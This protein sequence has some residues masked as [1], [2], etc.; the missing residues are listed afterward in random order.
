MAFVQT[1]KEAVKNLEG[2][3]GIAY[4]RGVIQGY[5]KA[6]FKLVH[7]GLQE[8][9]MVIVKRVQIVSQKS[10]GNAVVKTGLLIMRLFQESPHCLCNFPR[11]LAVELSCRHP[12]QHPQ[13][14]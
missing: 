2:G 1:Q 14:E 8:N 12:R 6:L 7:I 13:R 11:L 5:A 10:A 9:K 3:S 4:Q